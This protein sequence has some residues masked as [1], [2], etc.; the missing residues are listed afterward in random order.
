M[1]NLGSGTDGEV[2][3]DVKEE[4]RER[5]EA[6]RDLF[7]IL[8][9]LNREIPVIV[10]GKNDV[11]ALR[12][13]GLKGEIIEIHGGKSLYELSEEIH[14]RFE[15]VILLIDWDRKGEMLMKTLGDYLS[16]LWEGYSTIRETLRLLSRNEAFE[17]EH[18]PG[19]M[20]RLKRES[21]AR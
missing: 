8:S 6:L 3:V 12:M 14:E 11:I 18:I 19:L 2:T 13:L 20:E 10:E 15:Q 16:G 7:R 17:I 5:F 4:S 1:N 9:E 21:V